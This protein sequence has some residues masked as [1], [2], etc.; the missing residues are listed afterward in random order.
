MVNRASKQT[1]KFAQSGQ[2]KRTIDSRRKHQKFKKQIEARKG[3]RGAP[4][5]RDHKGD[6]DGDEE[7]EDDD[8]P[9]PSK[10]AKGK[11]RA[12]AVD[13][14]EEDEDEDVGKSADAVASKGK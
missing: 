1:K 10:K 11:G 12:K 3:V 13:F 5:T 4:A 9:G 6:G 14:L 2:L 8:R 7:P